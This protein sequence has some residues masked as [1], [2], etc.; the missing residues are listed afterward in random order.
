MDP[1]HYETWVFFR[2]CVTIIWM[3]A[4]FDW[5]GH[6]L[7]EHHFLQG[8]SCQNWPRR[9]KLAQG[10]AKVSDSQDWLLIITNMQLVQDS[11]AAWMRLTTSRVSAEPRIILAMKK[12]WCYSVALSSWLV[13]LVSSSLMRRHVTWRSR[14]SLWFLT[15]QACEA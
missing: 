15:D 12:K 9:S 5:K 6:C 4:M 8:S 2:L 1:V 13:D 14:L 10:L 7:S 3:N 11:N